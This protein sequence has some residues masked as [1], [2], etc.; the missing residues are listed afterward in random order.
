[1][2]KVRNP[3][4]CNFF[5]LL[6]ILLLK[7]LYKVIVYPPVITKVPNK[8]ILLTMYLKFPLTIDFLEISKAKSPTESYFLMSARHFPSV[9]PTVITY[10]VSLI[11]F[12]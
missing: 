2:S 3:A 6:T 1:M 11:F 7:I 9:L 5:F 8:G 10:Y 12:T 4:Y